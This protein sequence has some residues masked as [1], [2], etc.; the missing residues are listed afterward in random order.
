MKKYE[1]DTSQ[2]RTIHVDG[3]EHTLHRIR[4]V[5]RI[6]RRTN[7]PYVIPVGSIGGWVEEEANLS[8]R[9]ECWIDGEAAVFGKG[10]VHDNAFVSGNAMVYDR[11]WAFGNAVVCD[12]AEVRHGA[13][14]RDFVRIHGRAKVGGK[15]T[16]VNGHTVLGG[17][18]VIDSGMDYITISVPWFGDER[19]QWITCYM[20]EGKLLRWDYG[21]GPL[22]FQ[23]IC[24]KVDR[25]NP[26]MSTLCHKTMLSIE[27]VSVV[28]AEEKAWMP[29]ET[30]G[31]EGG[32]DE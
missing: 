25:D 23:E 31:T 30:E 28:A 20:D 8:Q 32:D 4:A 22:T 5:R 3:V 21:E 2:T 11:G 27:Y 17:A 19:L 13:D 26:K 16:T 18:A 14:V 29:R 7:T 10:Y 12:C 24:E 1:I 15:Y 9:G 6:I